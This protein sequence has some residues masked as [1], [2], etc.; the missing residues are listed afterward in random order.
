MGTWDDAERYR[1]QQI[2]KAVGGCPFCTDC[3]SV[4]RIG[5]EFYC[6]TCG[7]KWPVVPVKESA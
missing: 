1:L 3:R 7:K 2:A 6:Q 5:L 4:E